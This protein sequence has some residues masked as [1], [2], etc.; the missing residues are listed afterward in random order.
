M[1]DNFEVSIIGSGRVATSLSHALRAKGV[2]LNEI[3]GRSLAQAKK[4]S[5]EIPDTVATDSLDFSKSS[6]QILVIA[7]TDD[8]IS[9]VSN[10]IICSNDQIIA[11]TS[12]TVSLGVLKYKNSGIFYPLQTFT[13]DKKVDFSNVPILI[14]GKNIVIKEKLSEFGRLLSTGVKITSEVERQKLHIAA[15]FASNFTNRMLAAAEDILHHTSLDLNM[16]RPLVLASIENVF[17]NGPDQSLTG[18]AKR[19]DQSTIDKHIEALLHHPKLLSIYKE[20]THQI[21]EKNKK[22]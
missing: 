10:S 19:G 5:D 11:H 9:E 15:V 12:G 17:N 4:L 8:A 22:H 3:Y 13:T 20:I 2:K 7:I 21:I 1:S 18:P 14:D 6:S 16:L